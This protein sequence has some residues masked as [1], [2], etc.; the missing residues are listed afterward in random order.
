[1]TLAHQSHIVTI[2]NSP[3]RGRCGRPAKA[4]WP[5]GWWWPP[6]W[7]NNSDE[8]GS[9][10]LIG[11]EEL[12]SENGVGR[13]W[14]LRVTEWLIPK[15]ATGRGWRLEQRASLGLF[16]PI[17]EERFEGPPSTLLEPQSWLL[18]PAHS[19]QS[20]SPFS[21]VLQRSPGSLLST[22]LHYPGQDHLLLIFESQYP[23]PVSLRLSHPSTPF[24][25]PDLYWHLTT[26]QITSPLAH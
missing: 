19:R 12:S 15:V 22:S 21:S 2:Q 14:R 9:S 23:L 10:Q 18:P 24:S 13:P 6:S 11:N 17:I 4:C 5:G 3:E 7:Y 25:T 8:S 20:P 1:M 26:L 16:C